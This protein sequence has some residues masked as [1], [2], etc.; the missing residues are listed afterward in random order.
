MFYFL[1]FL[2]TVSFGSSEDCNKMIVLDSFEHHG[3][4]TKLRSE[5]VWKN[6]KGSIKRFKDGWL[7]TNLNKF[8]PSCQS[9][10]ECNF[11]RDFEDGNKKY[12]D[13]KLICTKEKIE[14][15]EERRL[16]QGMFESTNVQVFVFHI[17]CWFLRLWISH[18]FG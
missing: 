13:M 6:N 15:Q 8:S 4:F 16:L 12:Q 9:P 18:Y 11:W 7:I 14:K 3:I 2:L 17:K 1:L 5:M 10:W